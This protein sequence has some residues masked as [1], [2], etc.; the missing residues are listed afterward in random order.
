MPLARDEENQ[1]I[2]AGIA[3]KEGGGGRREQAEELPQEAGGNY[4]N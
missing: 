4:K 2:G 3:T 1:S